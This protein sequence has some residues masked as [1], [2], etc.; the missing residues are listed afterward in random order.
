[1]LVEDESDHADLF[2][3]CLESIPEFEF[4]LL[5]CRDVEE[6]RQGLLEP[7]IGFIFLD[8][9]IDGES[10]LDL[11]VEMRQSGDLRPVVVLTAQG[12]EYI[13]VDMI[14]AGADEYVVKSDLNPGLLKELITDLSKKSLG[15]SP[16]PYRAG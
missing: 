2:R 8:Y 15:R 14:R 11:L 9:K 4:F 1:M 3:R 6:A 16:A 12:N 10:S 13:A 7:E 5:H